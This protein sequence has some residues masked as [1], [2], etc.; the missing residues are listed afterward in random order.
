M[1]QSKGY[2]LIPTC[3]LVTLRPPPLTLGAGFSLH[4]HRVGPFL[5]RKAKIHAINDSPAR[6]DRLSAKLDFDR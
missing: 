2:G 4:V 6:C 3:F 5:N 1:N